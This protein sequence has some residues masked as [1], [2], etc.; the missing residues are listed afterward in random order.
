[1]PADAPTRRLARFLRHHEEDDPG[2]VGRALE[3]QGFVVDVVLVTDETSTVEL[4]GVDV[5]GVLGSKWSV[6]D[7][8]R[9]GGWIDV[10]LDAIRR[11]HE[12]GTPVLGVCFGAQALCTAMGGSVEPTGTTELGWVE[13]A[14][15]PDE[16][17]PEGPWFEFH[18]D[19][20]VL[21]PG[22]LVLASNDVGVQAFRIG[23]HLG[24]QF[25]PEIDAAQFARWRDAGADEEAAVHGASGAVLL[26]EIEVHEPE[27]TVRVDRLVVGFLERAFD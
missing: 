7:H 17:L 2:L 4:D 22:A 14:G 16:G 5:L 11:A 26:K 13:L 9:V 19:R 8:E 23:R 6:Y 25:H 24:V 21:P 1:M 15:Q 12:R 18:A 20:C 27:A 10:E 3:R